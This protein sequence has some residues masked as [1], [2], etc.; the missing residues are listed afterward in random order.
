MDGVDRVDGRDADRPGPVASTDTSRAVRFLHVVLVLLLIGSAAAYSGTG[1]VSGVGGPSAQRWG[2]A[3]ATIARLLTLPL[4]TPSPADARTLLLPLAA[5]VGLLLCALSGARAV[6]RVGWFEI[7]AG[8]VLAWSAASAAGNGTFDV[9]RGWMITFAAGAAWAT[10]LRR[11]IEPQ[12]AERLVCAALIAAAGV[13]VLALWYRQR[14][15]LVHPGWPVGALT[16]LAGLCC[17]TTATGAG[18][19]LGL[20]L[21]RIGGGGKSGRLP[22]DSISTGHKPV[23]RE[24]SQR[25]WR[26]ALIPFA[27]MLVGGVTVWLTGRRAALLGAGAAVA[28]TGLALLFLRAG[29][30]HWRWVVAAAGLAA[31]LGG[32]WWLRGQLLD[33]RREIGGSIGYRVTYLSESLPLIGESPLLGWAPD[34]FARVVTPR[35]A[36]RR[37]EQ[38]HVFHGN[39]DPQAHNEWLQAV[40][41]LGIPGGVAYGAIPLAVVIGAWRSYRRSGGRAARRPVV[42]GLAAGVVGLAVM[43]CAS[44]TLRGPIVVAWWWSW[45]GLLMA[46][47]PLAASRSARAASGWRRWLMGAAG[48][49]L[50][51]GAAIEARRMSHQAEGRRL[52]LRG[53]A[54][55]AAREH[56]GTARGRWGIEAWLSAEADYGLALLES[57]RAA[58]RLTPAAQGAAPVELR[59]ADEACAFWRALATRFPGMFDHAMQYAEALLL[60]GRRD[61][62]RNVLEDL[63]ERTNP[64]DAAANLAMARE[65]D[66]DAGSRLRRMVRAVREG[67]LT[68]EMANVLTAAWR[69]EAAAAKWND[70]VRQAE[71][72]LSIDTAESE[73][74]RLSPEV[75]RIEAH[76]RR[77]GGD[78][79]GAID[80]QRR[81]AERYRRWYESNDPL[82]R[83]EAAEQDAWFVLAEMAYADEP[84][85]L[86]AALEAVR[87][88]ERFAI[89]GHAHEN[90]RSDAADPEFLGDEKVPT[91]TPESLRP[92]WRLSALLHLAAGR[93]RHVLLR[94]LLSLPPNRQTLAEAEAEIVTL[95]AELA[96]RGG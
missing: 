4:D 87:W 61:D 39:F 69:D 15:G 48:V 45:L 30:R 40:V 46:A 58:R 71:S 6:R 82:R 43:E 55:G 65:F 32:G 1:P 22:K 44:V 66:G 49:L 73:A 93:E 31:G 90:V 62:A 85:D 47:G 75:L 72:A 89:L 94:V 67:P 88:A 54:L 9:S 38:P 13:F 21:E 36:L 52:M 2:A 23:P 28:L 7:A 35:L 50:L 83:R 11:C 81:A 10:V 59:Q 34:G 60:A 42:S 8:A 86:V 70:W 51:V 27:A 41:E 3:L 16:P 79:R 24:I 63:L 20:A 78:L 84:P 18:W 68:D 29:G 80:V 19:L 91:V 25:R 56:F 96:R 57:A 12:R 37:A 53:A 64:Y 95:R 17:L 5:G 76:R 14:A 92:M 77:G 74:A 26:G 33:P